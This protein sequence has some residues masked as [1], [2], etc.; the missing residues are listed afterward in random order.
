MFENGISDGKAALQMI[1]LQCL[2]VLRALK[3]K[4]FKSKVDKQLIMD[5]EKCI[6]YVDKRIN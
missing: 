3:R 6:E 4:W 1:K 2:Y 5:I